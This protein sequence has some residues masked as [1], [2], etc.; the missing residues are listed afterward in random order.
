MRTVILERF[1]ALDAALNDVLA[2]RYARDQV[3]ADVLADR[4]FSR[5][6]MQERTAML[7]EVLSAEDLVDRWPFLV[8]VLRR[9][10]TLRNALAHGFVERVEDGEFQVTSV[11]RGKMSHRVYT[12][13]QL[14][15][16]AWQSQ[17][18]WTELRAVWAVLV[19]AADDWFEPE[20][21]SR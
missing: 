10:S 17:V 8:E 7:A 12:S 16:L 14:A 3:A 5:I 21:N 18:A 4:V 11:N 13:Q 2:M 6:S 9:L 1:T 15:W 19:P 20:S